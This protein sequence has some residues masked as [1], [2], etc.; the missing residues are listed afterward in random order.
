VRA[1]AFCDI[2]DALEQ[3]NAQSAQAQA[4]RA[5]A[6]LAVEPVMQLGLGPTRHPSS[7][8]FHAILRELG[9]L[10]D[11]KQ[12]DYGLANDPFANVRGSSEWGIKSWVGAM[13]RANDKLRRLQ[14]Y[15]QAGRLSNESVEDSFRDLAVYAVIALVLWEQDQEKGNNK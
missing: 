15:A 8:R 6:G 7:E 1:H 9:D 12:Q 5:Y 4:S 2:C 14:K 3:A 11:K 10:H 13:V